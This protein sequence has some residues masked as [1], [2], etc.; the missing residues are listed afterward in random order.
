[1]MVKRAK[2]RDSA[3]TTCILQAYSFQ[4]VVFERQKIDHSA[5]CPHLY[6]QTIKLYMCVCGK[7]G[8]VID[9]RSV[10]T[11]HRE[12]SPGAGSGLQNG[13]NLFPIAIKVSDFKTLLKYT[14]SKNYMQMCFFTIKWPVLNTNL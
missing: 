9:Y 3:K 5:F 12:Y 14:V 6:T 11:Y 4:T 7:G 13:S 10:F 1:M 2:Q 8:E